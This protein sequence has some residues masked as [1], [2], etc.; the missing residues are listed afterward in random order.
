MS[1]VEK[2]TKKK[3]SNELLNILLIIIG[4]FFVFI[5][6][7]PDV[8]S[9]DTLYVGGSGLGNYTSIQDAINDSVDGDT[10]FVYDEGSP[11]YENLV[12]NRSII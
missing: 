11:Y 7:Q 12:V 4:G 10:V 9:A 1:D 3:D 8:A 6:I 2:E 5:A